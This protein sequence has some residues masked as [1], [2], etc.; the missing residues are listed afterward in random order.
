MKHALK[1]FEFLRFTHLPHTLVDIQR[2]EIRIANELDRC[3]LR[4]ESQAWMY[5]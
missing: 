3:K 1:T 4:V 5:R 2:K